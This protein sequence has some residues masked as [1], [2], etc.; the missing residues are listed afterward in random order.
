[1]V[2]FGAFLVIWDF[3]EGVLGAALSALAAECA[4]E[5][6][7]GQVPSPCRSDHAHSSGLTEIYL[8]F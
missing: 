7:R 8:T 6:Q 3:G 4:P 5:S 2:S 1:M